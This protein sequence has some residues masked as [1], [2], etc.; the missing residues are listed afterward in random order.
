VAAGVLIVGAGG[1]G[2]SVAD[3][4]LA[5]DS[6]AGFVDDRASLQERVLGIPVLGRVCD[7]ATLRLRHDRLVVAIGDNQLRRRLCE[8]ALALGFRLVAVV[9][10]RAWCS[11]H[12]H[13]GAGAL[14]MAGA[15]V[16]TAAMVGRGA[17]V[18]TAAVVDHHAKVGD[19]AHLGVGACM[20]GGAL[21]G[22]G[23]WLQEGTVL[24]AGQAVA[25]HQVVMADNS[26]FTGRDTGLYPP[27]GTPSMNG[28]EAP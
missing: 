6:V 4:L 15:V 2:Q 21:L 9:H 19:F 25:A 8:S 28:T 18:N 3:A 10:P 22:E 24:R 17:I 11:P 7:L 14:I 23:A 16:G 5:Q 12:A 1:F 27:S 13:I 26:T 20:A